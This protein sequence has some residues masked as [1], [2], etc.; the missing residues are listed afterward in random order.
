MAPAA[1]RTQAFA[2]IV[3]ADAA[4]ATSALERTKQ[5][6]TPVHDHAFLE[7]WAAASGLVETAD[8]PIPAPAMGLML[9]SLEAL[10]RVHEFDAFEVLL[11]LVGRVDGLGA[12]QRHELLASL[13]LRRGFLDSAAEEWAAAC[14]ESGP[15]AAAFAGLAQVAAARGEVLDAR[16]FAEGALELDPSADAARR[17]LAALEA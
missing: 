14:D 15:D 1:A 7:A 5:L 10:L 9:T 2:A 13:Y 16:V 11:G 4:V 3:A 12:R 17:V 8:A 6:D